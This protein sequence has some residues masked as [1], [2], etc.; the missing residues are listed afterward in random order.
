MPPGRLLLLSSVG[1]VLA[2]DDLASAAVELVKIAQHVRT[3]MDPLH[4]A[5]LLNRT[6]RDHEALSVALARR[7]DASTI[8]RT[9]QIASGELIFKQSVQKRLMR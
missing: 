8:R 3:K 6:A 9:W 4:G 5:D 1:A 2:G 7:V